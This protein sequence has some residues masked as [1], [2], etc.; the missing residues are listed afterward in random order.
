MIA[1]RIDR[2]GRKNDYRACALYIAA[3]PQGRP[4]R[5]KLSQ[6]WYAGGE[7]DDFQ[8]GLLEVELTQALNTR[9][10]TSK[11][12]H[13]KDIETRLAETLGLTRHQRHCGVHIDTWHIHILPTYLLF[14]LYLR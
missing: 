10:G 1:K 9:A 4:V 8:E 12:Y 5:E 14:C 2:K 11:T 3:V 7:T 13:L 6:K